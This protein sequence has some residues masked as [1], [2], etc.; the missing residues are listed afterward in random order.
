MVPLS[1]L[2]QW[3]SR[4]RTT[5]ELRPA[6][7][8]PQPGALYAHLTDSNV[9]E[10]AHIIDAAP[11]EFGIVHVRFQ[12]SYRYQDRIRQAGE[13][14]LALPIFIERFDRLIETGTGQE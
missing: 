12:L 11:D 8:R 13:R 9:I 14:L 5:H 10:L 6:N 7:D 3:L 4:S 1:T 2:R